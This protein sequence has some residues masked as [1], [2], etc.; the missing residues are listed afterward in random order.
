MA[1]LALYEYTLAMKSFSQGLQLDPTN[2][3][4]AAKKDEAEAHALY[5][6]ACLQA[7]IG[8]QKR[9]LVLKLRAVRHFLSQTHLNHSLST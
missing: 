4:M 2:K 7:H 5:E 9:D 3:E 6:H 1:Y 8:A